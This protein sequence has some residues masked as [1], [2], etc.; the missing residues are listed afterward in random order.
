MHLTSKRFE[1]LGSR[2][3]WQCGMR[4]GGHPLGDKGEEEW[5]EELLEGRPGWG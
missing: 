4:L 2:K 1:V 3:A 5:D